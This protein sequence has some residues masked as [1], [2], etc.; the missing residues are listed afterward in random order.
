MKATRFWLGAAVLRGVE[1][2][3]PKEE[4]LFDDQLSLELLPSGWKRFLR[5][6][7]SLGLLGAV[8]AMRERQYPGVVG[9][10]L[11]RT[12][13]IDDVL[14]DALRMGLDQVVFLGAGFDTRPYRIQG[15]ERTRVFEVDHPATQSEKEERLRETMGGIPPHV[16]LVPIDFDRE[17]LEDVMTRAGLSSRARTLFVWEGVTQYISSDAVDA[18]LRYISRRAGRKNG[19]VFTYVSQGI[20]DGSARSPEDE[21]I[22][23]LAQRTGVPWV[24]GLDPEKL[25]GFLAA[26]G[27]DLV[28]HVGTDEYRERYLN[29][30][31]REMAIFEGERVALAKSSAWD[32]S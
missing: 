15:I 18:T 5:L 23:S 2:L 10:L 13:Y 4:R 12:R 9:N 16:T 24:F 19:L 7:K 31:G 26:R 29:P 20:I 11:C 27:L 17:G 6:V 14:R 21:K 30:L 1:S 8:L 22:M 32:R 25:T 3:R 28:E